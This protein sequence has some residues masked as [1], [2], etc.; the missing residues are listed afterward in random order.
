MSWRCQ[1]LGLRPVKSLPSTGATLSMRMS[2]VTWFS[3]L[4]FPRT[5]NSV[6]HR[7]TC[8]LLSSSQLLSLLFYY[9]R[10]NCSKINQDWLV[11]ILPGCVSNGLQTNN[12]HADGSICFSVAWSMLISCCCWRTRPLPEFFSPSPHLQNLQKMYPL[13]V[14]MLYCSFF[15]TRVLVFK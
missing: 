4:L 14:Y 12:Q 3:P 10:R 5:K 1:F 15:I 7:Q 8:V 9:T 2:L 6:I 11:R 13:E